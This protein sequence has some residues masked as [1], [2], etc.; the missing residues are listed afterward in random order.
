MEIAH[1]LALDQRK[2]VNPVVARPQGLD[3]DLTSQVS[4]S[5]RN[6][7]S[8]FVNIGDDVHLTTMPRKMM[9]RCNTFVP[10]LASSDFERN[11]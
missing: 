1:R 6:G 3:L 5:V 2:V 8:T 4:K 10:K 11:R 9:E 7:A